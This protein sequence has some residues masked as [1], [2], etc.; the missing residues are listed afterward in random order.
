[1]INKITD[2]EWGLIISDYKN[3]LKPY[4]LAKKYNHGS[5]TIINKLC[6]LGLHK[7]KHRYTK[8]DIEFLREHYPK[9][10]WDIITKRF[11]DT[12]KQ[13]I[14]AIVSKHNIQ[15]NIK[16]WSPDDVKLLHQNIGKVSDEKLMD[17]FGGKYT[18][19][20][21]KTK[22]F[23][24]FGYSTSKKW[25]IQEDNILKEHYSKMSPR[26]I[27][28][29]LPNRSY[30]SV[31][32]RAMKLHLRSSVNRPWTEQENEYIRTHW[33]LEPDYIMGI[34]LN[35]S[36]RC[37]Q[38]QRNVLGLYRRNMDIVTYE[39]LSKYIRGHILEW[40]RAS[41]KNCGYKCVFTGSKKFQ[42]HHLYNVNRILNDVFKFNDVER[43]E[44]LSD[45]SKEE[46]DNI[47]NLFILEQNKYPLGVCI[48]KNIHALFH[49]LYGQYNN[50]PE[51]WYQFEKDYKSGLYDKYTPK[52]N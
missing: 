9:G 26:E 20:A 5:L 31:I 1:M 38:Y 39:S 10:D 50:S 34:K 7:K 37:V 45:Y 17:L 24:A 21:I 11:P 33:E 13:T 15:A 14:Y 18:V 49:S 29:L 28:K 23:K 22:A 25:T 48:S 40:K 52:T 41:M 27:L 6:S 36:K 8:E 4:Q 35:R 46:L 12:S 32:S 47:V 51:Q 42:I 44:N 3:G 19:D 30:N 2:D 16:R 43:K